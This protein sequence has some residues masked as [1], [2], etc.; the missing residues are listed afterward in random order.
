VHNLIDR[1]LRPDSI[2][3]THN[4]LGLYENKYYYYY[5]FV[6][7]VQTWSSRVLYII[8]YKKVVR[9]KNLFKITNHIRIMSSS[10]SIYN[11]I[12]IC[13]HTIILLYTC[14][15]NILIVCVRSS[16]YPTKQFN[17]THKLY[18]NILCVYVSYRKLHNIPI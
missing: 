16:R 9:N 14:G 15:T 13:I 6:S 18:I 10:K 1:P 5:V 8:I 4:T 17:N 11:I 3:S 12:I 7:R 2:M